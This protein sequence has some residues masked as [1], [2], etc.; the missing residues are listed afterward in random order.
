MNLYNKFY[1]QSLYLYCMSISSICN[2]RIPSLVFIRGTNS[3]TEKK[4]SLPVD[5]RVGILWLVL[6]VAVLE[7][8]QPGV[9]PVIT[10]TVMRPTKLYEV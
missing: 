1:L 6:G 8:G 9:A 5:T 2:H 4:A 3:N 10:I 7:A